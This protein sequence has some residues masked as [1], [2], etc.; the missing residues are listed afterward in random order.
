M[1]PSVTDLIGELGLDNRLVGVTRYCEEGFRKGREIV[2]GFSPKDIDER[3]ILKL[4]PDLVIAHSYIQRSIVEKLVN[5]Q[6]SVYCSNP[7]NLA[8]VLKEIVLISSLLGERARGMDI[9]EK[10]RSHFEDK[11]RKLGYNPRIYIEEYPKPVIVGG[12]WVW[13]LVQMAGGRPVPTSINPYSGSEARIIKDPQKV[14]AE[15]E[16]DI[17]VASYVGFGDKE[18]LDLIKE[19]AGWKNLNAVKRGNVFWIPSKYLWRPSP[20]LTIGFDKLCGIIDGYLKRR[21]I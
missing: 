19:R 6:V 15:E 12:E 7:R 9:A 20:N 1:A 4:N 10:M 11:G 13:D 18:R 3:K 2:G 5:D 8:D 17:I 14:F 21:E 16:P